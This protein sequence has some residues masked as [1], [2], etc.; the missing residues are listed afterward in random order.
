MGAHISVIYED[1]MIKKEIWNLAQAGEWFSFEAKELR[2]LDRKTPKGISRLWLLAVDAPALQR[3]RTHYGLKPKLKE[4]DF[5]ITLGYE[6]VEVEMEAMK[7][8]ESDSELL[9]VAI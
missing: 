7:Q 1:E 5:H 2:Y 3:L 6:Q 8:I 4:H 9:S